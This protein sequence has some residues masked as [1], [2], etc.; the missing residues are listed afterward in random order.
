[1]NEADLKKQ[2]EQDERLKR[3]HEKIEWKAD[4]IAPVCKNDLIHGEAHTFINFDSLCRDIE[5][6]LINLRS[7]VSWASRFLQGIS[8]PKNESLLKIEERLK[9]IESRHE[10]VIR[11]TDEI[12]K[13][14]NTIKRKELRKAA[15]G[16]AKFR[17]TAIGSVKVIDGG[18]Y[19]PSEP[20]VGLADDLISDEFKAW[21]LAQRKE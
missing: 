15:A 7:N 21:Q 2:R 13:L 20:Q 14:F 9:E 8:L 16:K 12:I 11:A 19:K 5:P 1:M 3:L 10:E 17:K 6:V 18:L 4:I